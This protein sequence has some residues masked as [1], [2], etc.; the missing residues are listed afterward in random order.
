M[1]ASPTSK[2]AQRR[3]PDLPVPIRNGAGARLGD[4]IHLGLGSAG[5]TWLALDLA[6]D[7]PE[8]VA[9]APFPG[10]AREQAR[11]VAVAGGIHVFGG[12]G[13][14]AGRTVS[15]DTVHRYDPVEDRWHEVATRCPQ[16]VLGGALW[17]PDG[18]VVLA[19]GGVNTAVIEGYFAQ[20]SAAGDDDT[21][22]ARITEAYFSM[23]PED[24]RFTADALCHDPATGRWS[25][26]GRLPF[27]PTVG[28]A[29]AVDGAGRITLV[30]GEIKP[31][32]RTCAARVGAFDGA[33]LRWMDLPDLVSPDAQASREG[34][35]GAFA[36]HIGET[37]VVA[38][39]T[40]FPGA[41]TAFDA[42][43]TW[44]HRGLTKT[45]HD[46]IH[47]LGAGGWQVVGRLP[48]GLASGLSFTLEDG[49]LLVGGEL[50]GG[51]AIADVMLLRR[52]GDAI[53]VA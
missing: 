11:A 9:R 19:V 6:A 3:I 22:K 29:T 4:Q 21:A 14:D 26:L 16:G 2:T 12:I 40:N 32:L 10:P 45:W 7:R 34:L 15:F 13:Q 31:G 49:V 52:D 48:R 36:G 33:Q 30:N 39:G 53:V 41:R 20:M 17:S 28:A 43:Q 50:Q 51:E 44:A 38:G 47:V 23:R 27:A 1:I 24:Y 5:Q 18:R 42:G 46:T 37:L 35:A 25:V 8:W